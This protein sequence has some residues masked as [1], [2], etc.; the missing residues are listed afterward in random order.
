[1]TVLRGAGK[2]VFAAADLLHRRPNGPRVLIYHQ[3]GAGLGRQMEVSFDDFVWQLDWLADNREVTSLDD[4]ILRWAADRSENLVVITF[5]D[6]YQ[7]THRVAFPAL[8][9]RKLPFTIYLSTSHMEK[10]ESRPGAE[11]L[12]WS[13]VA[14]MVE[15]R[16]VTLGSHT[17]THVDLRKSTPDQVEHELGTSDELIMSNLGVKPR[18]FAYPWGFWS[19]VADP[20][21]R[22][23]YDSAALGSR[24]R[25]TNVPDPYLLHRVPVQLS[26]RRMWF[27]RRLARGLL[28]EER[29]RRRLRAYSGP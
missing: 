2:A 15:S 24:H 11:P 6:G 1:M 9:E 10:G 27:K 23:R 19:R 26:D 21:V 17:H 5:D 22:D 20:Y 16:L 4:A 25:A 12:R 13:E 18:H 29:L 8:A 7:D 28:F 14:E 3:I